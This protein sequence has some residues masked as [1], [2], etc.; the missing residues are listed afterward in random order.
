MRARLLAPL[1]AQ[2][3]LAA[4]LVAPAAGQAL[5]LPAPQAVKM[6]ARADEYRL[7]AAII[8]NLAKFVEWPASAFTESA[9]PL[10]V[11]VLGSDPFGPALENAMRGHLVAGHTIATRRVMTVESGCHVL[12][13]SESETKRLPVILDQLR[14]RSVLSI[15]EH[16]GFLDQGGIVSLTTDGERIRFAVNGSAAEQARLKVSARVLALAALHR[17]PGGTP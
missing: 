15:G 3:V 14:N 6:P 10:V 12:F 4:W 2:S 7:K 1:V 5:S 17:S 13:V 9:S 8:Y 11:C 16:D